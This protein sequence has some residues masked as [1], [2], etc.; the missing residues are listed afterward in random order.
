[1][2]TRGRDINPLVWSGHWHRVRRQNGVL[3]RWLADFE[4]KSAIRIHV[5]A[6]VRSAKKR[7]RTPLGGP[8]FIVTRRYVPISVS[9]LSRSN[10]TS[11]RA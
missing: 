8:A 10:S 7:G 2:E 9:S 5:T 11:P 6:I 4:R 3:Y 1:M